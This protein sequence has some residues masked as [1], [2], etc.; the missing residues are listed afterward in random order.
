MPFIGYTGAIFCGLV[1]LIGLIATLGFIHDNGTS[2]AA[3]AVYIGIFTTHYFCFVIKG[4]KFT[5]DEM[6]ITFSSLIVKFNNRVK[7]NMKKGKFFKLYFL[8]ASLIIYLII[9]YI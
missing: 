5:N 6:K 2:I 4:Q 9:F 7:Q 1:S 8:I 3:V